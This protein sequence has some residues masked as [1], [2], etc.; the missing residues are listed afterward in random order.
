ML[1]ANLSSLRYKIVYLVK[2][3]L[4]RLFVPRK[5]YCRIELIIRDMEND[6]RHRD[7][8]KMFSLTRRS[9]GARNPGGGVAIFFKRQKISLKRYRIKTNGFEIL[10]AKGK[11]NNN[12]RPVYVIVAYLPPSLSVRSSRHALETISDAILRMKLETNSPYIIVGGDF[13]GFDLEGAVEDYD[14]VSVLD[15]PPT[16][17]AACLDLVATS[18]PECLISIGP[19]LENEDGV[20]SDHE[21]LLVSTH[22]CMYVC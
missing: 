13:N 2:M 17:K 20:G 11:I 5:M 22:V 7:A 1:I 19:P 14:D 3:R 16:R 9:K 10:A 6:L 8:I 15:S 12:T 4:E 18:I 21:I